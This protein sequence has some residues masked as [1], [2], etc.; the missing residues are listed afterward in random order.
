MCGSIHRVCML[1]CGP[2]A[3]STSPSWDEAFK[4][5]GFQAQLQ[6]IAGST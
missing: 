4:C 6:Y 3:L 5:G 1:K 2:V